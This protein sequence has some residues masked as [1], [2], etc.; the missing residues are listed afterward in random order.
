[1]ARRRIEHELG[2]IEGYQ[3]SA[4][5]P[6]ESRP[7]ASGSAVS[8]APKA[9]FVAAVDRIE[10]EIVVLVQAAGHPYPAGFTSPIELPVAWFPPGLQEGALVRF[11]LSLYGL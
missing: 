11:D 7:P 3:P 6:L 2:F 10:G 5:P 1:M 9:F 4:G 8:Q